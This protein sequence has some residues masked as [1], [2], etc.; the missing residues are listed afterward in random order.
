[1][2]ILFSAEQTAKLLRMSVGH[3][4]KLR[5]AGNGPVPTYFGRSV[6]YTAADIADYINAGRQD[7]H[8]PTVSIEDLIRTAHRVDV[9]DAIAY[10]EAR[11]ASLS[12]EQRARLERVAS[13]Y[14]NTSAVS[15]A[16][17]SVDG[18]L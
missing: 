6:S 4:C 14:S 12:D 18:D 5:T 15:R 16:L 10:L 8:A 7:E 11:D 13:N 17:A 1:M 9:D 2:Q 3:L